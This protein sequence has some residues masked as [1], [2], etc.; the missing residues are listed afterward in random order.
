MVAVEDNDPAEIVSVMR[1]YG[2]LAE[3][4]SR[5]CPD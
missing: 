5:V 4:G 1:G 3:V 2:I